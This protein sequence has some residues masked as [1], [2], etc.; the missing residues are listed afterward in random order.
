MSTFGFAQTKLADISAGEN[1]IGQMMRQPFQHHSMV[2]HA[3]VNP[4][5][6]APAKRFSRAACGISKD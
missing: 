6:S 5:H 2:L 1:S 4:D 3:A